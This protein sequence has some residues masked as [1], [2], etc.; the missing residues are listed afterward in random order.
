[1]IYKLTIVSIH[2]AK[3]QVEKRFNHRGLRQLNAHYR[4]L[5]SHA[6]A[7][8]LYNVKNMILQ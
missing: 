5:V 7:M 1:M 8:S 2:V 6:V 4:Q 3:V